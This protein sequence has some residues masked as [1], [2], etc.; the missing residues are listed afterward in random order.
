MYEVFERSGCILGAVDIFWNRRCTVV[1]Y[2]P[3][4]GQAGQLKNM[5]VFRLAFILTALILGIYFYCY[6]RR[7][8]RFYGADAD[9]TEFRI[10]AAFDIL[11]DVIA[12]FAERIFRKWKT[13]GA[14]KV[15]KKIYD[16]GLLP[17]IITGILLAYGYM[18]MQN[19]VQ[20]EYQLE[21]EKKIGNYKLLL[22]S[23]IHYGTIQ[24]T[25][26]LKDKVKEMNEQS[27]DIVVLCGD[28]VEEGTPHGETGRGELR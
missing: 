8:M 7:V 14:Y 4:D 19:A 28:I 23:D 11:L 17:V 27:P 22:L 21:T 2:P 10:L 9:R 16:C 3:S 5:I 13:D 1:S 26:I 18:N 12:I 24:D 15:C 25:E 6:M 20:T